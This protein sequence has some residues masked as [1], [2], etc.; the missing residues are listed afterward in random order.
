M[1]N[2]KYVI[3]LGMLLLGN[4]LYG[5]VLLANTDIGN[6]AILKFTTKDNEIKELYSNIVITKVQQIYS[7]SITPDR[8]VKKVSGEEVIFAHEVINNG[9]G[10]DYIDIIHDYPVTYNVTVHMDI[11][12]NGEIDESEDEIIEYLFLNSRESVSILVKVE[13]PLNE[14]NTFQ[15]EI[16]IESKGDESKKSSVKETIIYIKKEIKV[17]FNGE[18]IPVA[19]QGGTILFEN[20]IKNMSNHKMSF[21]LF[22]DKNEST[23]I[24]EGEFLIGT[25]ND[26]LPMEDSNDDGI[27]DT[28]EL[29][30]EE[31]INVYFQMKLNDDIKDGEYKTRINITS[32]DDSTIIM[33]G[34]NKLLSIEI[35]VVRK[36]TI[37]PENLVGNSVQGGTIIFSHTIKNEGNIL[38]GSSMKIK[39]ENLSSEFIG[40]IYI[41]SNNNNEY[42]ENE[43]MLYELVENKELDPKEEIRIF[44][45]VQVLEIA[46][47]GTESTLKLKVDLE[48]GY[49]VEP[50]LN[51]VQDKIIIIEEAVIIEKFQSLDGEEYTKNIQTASPGDV[52]YYML[53]ITN[54]GITKALNASIEDYIPEY[55]TLE[56]VNNEE[57]PGLV[58]FPSSIKIKGDETLGNYEKATLFP[59]IG[60]KGLVK[61]EIDTLDVDEKV[62]LYFHVK[63]DD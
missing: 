14:E 12:K 50:I 38:D 49:N 58:S 3:L 39:I 9:N 21:N 4:I 34:E 35:P 52:I 6:Q 44:L 57:S 59:E 63:V 25:I 18:N 7:V 26:L 19:K 47:I 53:E 8:L 29:E 5:M 30:I 56:N 41:D 36:I 33:S 40:N 1:A 37:A 15:R 23:F 62:R 48:D 10:E 54:V 55:T 32:S 31:E 46:E 20:K 16:K 42:D 43:D 24:E 11:N 28:G 22:V 17:E 2:F 60:E 51:E 61:V 27:I 13:T 45:V